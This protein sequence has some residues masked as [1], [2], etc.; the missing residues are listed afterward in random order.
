MSSLQ[1]CLSSFL[2][3]PESCT[4]AFVVCCCWVVVDNPYSLLSFVSLYHETIS[5]L[6]PNRSAIVITNCHKAI[7]CVVMKSSTILDKII[8]TLTLNQCTRNLAM[9]HIATFQRVQTELSPTL[10]YCCP[11]LIWAKNLTSLCDP[12]AGKTQSSFTFVMGELDG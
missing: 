6:N 10:F 9:P 2:Q 4:L 5:T 3:H 11:Q 7:P 12:R 8:A 1:G